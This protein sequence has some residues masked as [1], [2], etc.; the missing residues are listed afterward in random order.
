VVVFDVNG[1]FVI[2]AGDI[3]SPP[4]A[5]IRERRGRLGF[6]LTA[7][8]G[9]P[10]GGGGTDRFRIQIWD[11]ATGQVMYDD[12]AGSGESSDPTTALVEGS[13]ALHQY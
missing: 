9:Q 12:Q 4:G 2:G 8:D 5:Y 13:I 7:V 10:P 3:N 11:R 6:L 1:G